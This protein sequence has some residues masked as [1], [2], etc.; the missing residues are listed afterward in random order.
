[1]TDERL[2]PLPSV[3]CG[4]QLGLSSLLGA[5]CQ[6]FAEHQFEC[7]GD[8]LPASGPILDP[9]LAAL[10]PA[11][12]RT[13]AFAARFLPRAQREPTVIL[14]AFCRLMDDLVDEPPPGVGPPEIRRQLASWSAWLRDGDEA[15]IPEPVGLAVVVRALIA[16]HQL[17][18]EYLLGLLN[19]LESDLGLVQIPDFTT[20]RRYCFLVAGTVGL[21]MSH[22]VGARQPEA[23]AAA[24]ELGIAMQLTNILRDLGSDLRAGRCYLPADELAAFG[25]TGERL[26]TQALTGCRDDAFRKLMRFQIDRARR[27]Y[28]LGLVGV[29]LLP[30]EMRPAVLIAGRLYRAILDAIEASDYDVFQRRAATSTFTK[31]YEALTI[32]VRLRFSARQSM[33][34]PLAPGSE[35]LADLTAWLR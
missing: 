30:P 17:P 24:A 13:F 8:T 33:A 16:E 23:L 19:G 9:A 1:M 18:A 2:E 6:V 3:A 20:L 10:L 7:W 31:L 35:Q 26:A 28:A 22:L 14:Y 34:A 29:P 32:L 25:Y 4:L 15:A 21:A 12:A 11:K 5:C 27:Y